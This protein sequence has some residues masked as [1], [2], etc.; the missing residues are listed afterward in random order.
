[1]HGDEGIGVDGLKEVDPGPYTHDGIHIDDITE[2][3]PSPIHYELL[4][5]LPVTSNHVADFC[6]PART[7]A[8]SSCQNQ[9]NQWQHL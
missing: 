5:L 8:L 3:G 4:P 2:H 7:S 1:M 6:F 9:D